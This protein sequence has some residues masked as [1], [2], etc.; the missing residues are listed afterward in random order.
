MHVRHP[1]AHG[2]D[3]GNAD[4]NGGPGHWIAVPDR[5]SR[6]R[7]R[8]WRSGGW[9]RSSPTRSSSSPATASRSSSRR[10]SRMTPG[11][12]RLRTCGDTGSNADNPPEILWR[13][14]NRDHA[15][16]KI[17]G[18]LGT[19]AFVDIPRDGE[20]AWKLWLIP[21][22]EDERDPARL[23]SRRRGRL[24]VR[25]ELQHPG[26]DDRLDRLRP[27]GR[28]PGLPAALGASTGLGAG[29]PAR[30]RRRR[31]R[32]VV[33]VALRAAASPSARSSTRP[34][35]RPTRARSIS[36]SRRSRRG[37]GTAEPLGPRDDADPRRRTP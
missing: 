37:A 6:P 24:G 12:A 30:A 29:G 26:V 21:R 35:G 7:R 20:R 17:A 4:G 13:N 14:P 25:P 5:D 22:H 19:V 23:P 18:D 28:R 9:T 16:V 15:I 34:I 1:I 11:A 2:G 3:G 32:A 8:R 36:S 31:G 10:A 33:P 27:W